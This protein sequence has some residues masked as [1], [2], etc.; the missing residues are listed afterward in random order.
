MSA[1]TDT[2]TS[3]LSMSEDPPPVQQVEHEMQKHG[4]FVRNM[5]AQGVNEDKIGDGLWCD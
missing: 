3:V 4:E 5:N 2:N 1:N